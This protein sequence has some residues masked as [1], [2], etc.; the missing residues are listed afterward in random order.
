M[1]EELAAVAGVRNAAD[2]RLVESTARVLAED[3]WKGA[4]IHTPIQ[5]LMWQT[6][7]SRATARRVLTVALRSDELPTVMNL[8]GEGRL[9]LDQAHAVA[10][11]TPAEYE[12][13]VCNLALYATVPQIIKATRT[14]GFD[15]E[16]PDP[17]PRNRRG[18]SFGNADDGT[19][20]ARIRLAAEEGAVVEAALY[21]ERDRLHE[22]A[23]EA[24]KQAARSEGRPDTGTD[25]ELG[26]ER[27]TAADALVGLALGAL[28]GS[29]DADAEDGDDRDS[30]VVDRDDNGGTTFNGPGG[31]S[32]PRGI[33]P[34]VHIHLEA[35]TG[36]H[37][38]GPWIGHMHGGLHLP[39]WL[40]RQLTCDSDVSVVW[41]RNGIPLSTCASMR[42]PPDRLRRLIEHRDHYTCRVPGCDNRRWLQLHHIIHWEDGGPTTSSNLAALCPAHH[43]AHHLGLLGIVGDADAPFGSEDALQFTNE[44]GLP[45]RP[46]ATVTPPNPDDFPLVGPYR[47]P[48]GEKL[49]PDAVHFNRKE[50]VGTNT[51]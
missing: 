36:D 29:P 17:S 45:I 32:S 5:W 3:L 34:K 24:A 8:L 1:E 10:R 33:R 15:L 12:E 22:E 43:R 50:P 28:T 18:V 25:A 41:K 20:W 47:H 39:D 27:T 13:S 26:V 51:G 14:Y 2:G 16:A 4:G 48:T 9:S 49:I 38:S 37:A 42:T 19:W 46:G 35:P 23:R 11:Y 7:V 6:G 44:F 30:G 40:R 21:K 31:R